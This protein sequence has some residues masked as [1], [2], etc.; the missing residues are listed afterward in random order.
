MKL[1]FRFFLIWNDPRHGVE[2]DHFVD[3]Y[4]IGLAAPVSRR[5]VMG[6]A[7]YFVPGARNGRREDA[8]RT[9]VGVPLQVGFIEEGIS[10]ATARL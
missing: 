7:S 4:K 9:R 3:L 6:G 5:T 1:S 10:L 2:S 8:L